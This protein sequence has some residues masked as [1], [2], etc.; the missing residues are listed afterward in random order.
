[1]SY[2]IVIISTEYFHQFIED[3]L[4]KNAPEQEYLFV[5]YHS[6]EEV[7]DLYLQYEDQADGFITSGSIVQYV[8]E[9]SVKHAC[10]PIV[11]FGTDTGDYY[12][13]LLN[14]FL[15]N[16]N[17]NPSRVIMDTHLIIMPGFSIEDYL[18]REDIQ[19]DN[20]VF[21][22]RLEQMSIEELCEIEKR[23]AV[24]IARLWKNGRIDM[25]VCR[26]SSL[27]PILRRHGIPCVFSNPSERH[28]MEVYNKLLSSLEL[29]K[30][31]DNLPA[32]AYIVKR[33][34][35]GTTI[36]AMEEATLRSSLETFAKENLMEFKI[37]CLPNGL[38]ITLT[39]K[40][41]KYLTARFETC[42]LKNYLDRNLDFEVVV[43]YGIGISPERAKENAVFARKEA[44]RTGKSY[45]VD[46]NERGMGPLNSDK[47]FTIFYGENPVL[48]QIAKKCGISH[49]TIRRLSAI[50]S[51]DDSF[52][53][54]SAALAERLGGG[55][56]N[57]NRI[58]NSLERNGFA[59]ISYT[60]NKLGKGRPVKIYKVSFL[61]R[62]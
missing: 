48:D 58:L 41:V 26:Y 18:A 34:G 54:T 37:G 11:S 20:K 31:R 47:V 39:K 62:R 8:I 53:L 49:L 45:I 22:S 4:A 40:M 60:K 46:E 56:R 16:R 6:F 2:R 13:L 35:K 51:Y 38:E 32:Y 19:A 14:L 1:M 12:L 33:G 59:E 36:T 43:S 5:E 10:K 17:L 57:A 30:L 7:A 50:L 25:V 3:A 44:D 55:I 24:M 42:T 23:T 27:M 52:E 9:R 21:M 61:P 15:K 28:F 29:E